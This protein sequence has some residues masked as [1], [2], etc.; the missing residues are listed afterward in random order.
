MIV[1]TIRDPSANSFEGLSFKP[2]GSKSVN[3]LQGHIDP[4]GPHKGR[5]PEKE[6]DMREKKRVVL[7]HKRG[8]SHA[9]SARWVVSSSSNNSHAILHKLKV[10]ESQCLGRM[11]SQCPWGD[12]QSFPMELGLFQVPLRFYFDRHRHVMLNIGQGAQQAESEKR[13][14]KKTILFPWMASW[15]E[16]EGLH[17]GFGEVLVRIEATVLILDFDEAE[18]DGT[19]ALRSMSEVWRSLVEPWPSGDT[20][21]ARKPGI[22]NE[23]WS[24]GKCEKFHLPLSSVHVIFQF[25]EGSGC[26]QTFVWFWS[27]AWLR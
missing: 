24:H 19:M 2:G 7:L 12:V 23:M 14:E 3:L 8:W 26:V 1:Q 15:V 22:R 17:F 10:H 6:F 5:W 13:G 25:R 18:W 27:N 9:A 4:R 11:W 21:V 20:Y 16:M